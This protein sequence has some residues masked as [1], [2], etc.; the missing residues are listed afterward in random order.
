MAQNS[1]ST[2]SVGLSPDSSKKLTLINLLEFLEDIEHKG[3]DG[4][5]GTLVVHERIE[6]PLENLEFLQILHL[7]TYRLFNLVLGSGLESF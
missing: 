5:G 1:S 6:V 7:F 4:G 2:V 3:V